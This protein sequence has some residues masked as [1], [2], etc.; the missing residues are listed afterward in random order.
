M[1][2]HLLV[3]SRQHHLLR[4]FRPQCASFDTT[5][6]KGFFAFSLGVLILSTFFHRNRQADSSKP[7]NACRPTSLDRRIGSCSSPSLILRANE[8]RNCRTEYDLESHWCFHPILPDRTIQETGEDTDNCAATQLLQHDHKRLSMDIDST[9][10][11]TQAAQGGKTI[12]RGG[13]WS[14]SP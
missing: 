7:G 13:K 14:T 11:N 1:L 2:C 5:N 3:V 8:M 12:Y 9:T 6:A 10:S 4:S